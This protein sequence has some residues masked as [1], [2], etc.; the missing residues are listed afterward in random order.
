MD[1]GK[2][3]APTPVFSR[4]RHLTPFERVVLLG[5][6]QVGDFNMKVFQK[7]AQ[8]GHLDPQN[9]RL[10]GQS[11]LGRQ[12]AYALQGI[13]SNQRELTGRKFPFLADDIDELPDS[14]TVL[15]QPTGLIDT[16][17]RKVD[18]VWRLTIIGRNGEIPSQAFGDLIRLKDEYADHF[19]LIDD[20]PGSKLISLNYEI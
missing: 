19:T 14:S 8:G 13:R 9:F 11:A 4:A 2:E 15:L 6:E 10:S 7:Q 20:L 5:E 1:D 18:P 17:S 3:R 16:G 12:E